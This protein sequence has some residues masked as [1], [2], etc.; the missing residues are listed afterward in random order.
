MSIRTASPLVVLALLGLAACGGDSSSSA[1]VPANADVV[2]R[3]LDGIAWDKQDYTATATDGVITIAGV[4]DSSIAHNLHLKAADGTQ[5]EAS[6]DLPT[7]G[8]VGVADFAVT[9]GEYRIVCLIPGH[10]NMDS[11][12]TVD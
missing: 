5:L 7:R 12:L 6:I 4:N 10:N 8:D 11:K 3:A 1:T 2:V 9:A